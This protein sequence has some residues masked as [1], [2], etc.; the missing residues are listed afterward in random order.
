MANPNLYYDILEK[1]HVTEKSTVL[2]GIRNQYTFRV[3]PSANK[4][5]IKKAVETLFEVEVAKVNIVR[6]PGKHKRILGRPG[7][8]GPWKKA[9]V[10]LREGQSSDI[11]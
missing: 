4:S 1:P 10:T 11:V 7:H 8:T 3:A 6:L 9:L 2:Q 5:E